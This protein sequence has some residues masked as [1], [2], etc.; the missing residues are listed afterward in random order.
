MKYSVVQA[1][2]G[3]QTRCRMHAAMWNSCQSVTPCFNKIICCFYGRTI[4]F[5]SA[6]KMLFLLVKW[7]LL[8]SFKRRNEE[9]ND[10]VP[11][12]IPG[13][14]CWNT[15]QF[16]LPHPFNVDVADVNALANMWNQHCGKG[17]ESLCVFMKWLSRQHRNPYFPPLFK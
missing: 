6:S 9:R 8:C 1:Y 16:F 11:N 10:K 7:N 13:H 12:Y 3:M 5:C 4:F 15:C 14:Y 17:R 2:P